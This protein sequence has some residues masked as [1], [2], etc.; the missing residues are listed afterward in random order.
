MS[1]PLGSISRT[2]SFKFRGDVSGRVVV[3]KAINQHL[4]RGSIS[5]DSSVRRPA[6]LRFHRLATACCF[7]S[8]LWAISLFRSL[9]GTAA[10]SQ[11]PVIREAIRV[12]PLSTLC[13]GSL[14]CQSMG[15]TGGEPTT[16]VA[17]RTAGIGRR[18]GIRRDGYR[19]IIA[20]SGLTPATIAAS[21]PRRSRAFR[22][23][24]KSL[25]RRARELRGRRR[26]GRSIGRA[27][28]V[29]AMPAVRSS[30]RPVP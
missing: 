22:A 15:T 7:Q 5:I 13:A 24:A 8:M 25:R 2:A 20:R 4:K 11:T 19:L 27:S 26:G 1:R 23:W 29:R 9:Y 3:A 18:P 6:V 28:P 16:E 12:G 17:Q 30:S 21:A 14:K 10:M